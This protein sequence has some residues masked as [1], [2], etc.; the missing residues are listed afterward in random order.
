MFHS[1]EPVMK[2]TTLLLIL[3]TATAISGFAAPSLRL[4]GILAQNAGNGTG[5]RTLD[6]TGITN[7]PA[8]GNLLILNGGTLFEQEKN[9]R[10]KKVLN[11][12]NTPGTLCNDGKNVF[13][14]SNQVVTRIGRVENEWKKLHQFFLK[15]PYRHITIADAGTSGGFAAK[16]KIF[17]LDGRE[18]HAFTREGKL[19]GIV[20]TLPELRNSCP[21]TA[22]AILPGSG[23]LL[24]SSYYPDLKFYRFRT[25]GTEYKKDGWPISGWVTESAFTEG[26]VWGFHSAATRYG[27]S[28]VRRNALRKIGEH[29]LYLSGIAS[30]GRNGYYLNT[31]QGILHYPAGSF[32]E[33]VERIGGSGTVKTL[34]LNGSQIVVSLGNRLYALKLDDAC[35]SPLSSQ[36]NEPWRVGN[37]WSGESDG[38]AAD[39]NAF[40]VYD[41]KG[42]ILWRFQPKAEGA[43]RWVR[44]PGT[45]RDLRDMAVRNGKRF[46]LDAGTAAFRNNPN[47]IDAFDSD[48]VAVADSR[49]VSL[50][51]KGREQWTTALKEIRDIAVL[52][53]YLAVAAGDS[54]LLLDRKEGKIVFRTPAKLDHLAADGKW[55]IGSD[56]DQAAI[57]R[58]KLK[59]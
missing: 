45:F 20:L 51:V 30:D 2:T 43:E 3:G 21:Y 4:S 19:L 18:V 32:D 57:L 22:L 24:A 11:L 1:K 39:G 38:I 50:I 47:R 41:R 34:A 56:P 5:F 37:G 8:T 23:D 49:S 12:V 46:F 54:L 29:D 31:S 25:D 28:V 6:S 48:T 55:L 16:G 36:G 17:A 40:L 15:K 52:G 42:G 10:R 53:E 26:A 59:P 27:D 14:K 33:A 7:D 58:F 35:D 9:G 13:L 44:Q